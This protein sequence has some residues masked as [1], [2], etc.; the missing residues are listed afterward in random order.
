MT[1]DGELNNIDYCALAEFRY[2]IRK[3]LRLGEHAAREAGLEPQ[4]HQLLLTIKGL[5]ENTKA[6]IGELA[7]RLQ[8]QH[9][10]A[11]ELIDR[12]SER[13][14]VTRKRG[15]EDRREVIV[16]LSSRGEKVLRDLAVFHRD[17]LHEAGPQLIQSLKKLFAASAKPFAN[18]KTA[19][20][21]AARKKSVGA[22]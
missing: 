22:E 18:G 6:N 12:L 7:E 19:K 5:P 20:K 10:S 9:H 1:R 16:Q 3:F 15:S 8:I 17:E 14:L 4:Q 2:Q 11:V 13:G 21:P